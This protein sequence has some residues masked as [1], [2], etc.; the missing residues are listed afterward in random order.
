ML[1]KGDLQKATTNRT[2][3][4]WQG[5]Q[6]GTEPLIT[7]KTME[8]QTSREKIKEREGLALQCI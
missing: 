8:K 3:R 4:A 1:K 7:K 6:S 5:V 2:Q